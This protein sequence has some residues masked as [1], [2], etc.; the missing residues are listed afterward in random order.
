MRFAML[1][2]FALLSLCLVGPVAART[3]DTAGLRVMTFNVRYPNPDDGANVWANRRALFV[4]TIA[5]AAPDIIGTQELF[6]TQGADIVRALPRYAWFGRDRRGGHADEHMGIFYRRDRLRLIRHGDYWLSNTPSVVGSMAWSVTL[7]RMVNWG[8]FETRGRIR[9]RFVLFDT[10]F[11]H[12]DEDDGAR[13]RSAALLLDR[14]A[15]IAGNLPIVLTGDMN[16]TPDSPAYSKLAARLI[17]A[18]AAA[19]VRKGPERTFHDFTGLP[20]RRIDYIFLRGFTAQ[21]AEVRTDHAGKIFPSDHFPV[22]AQ[23]RFGM[24]ATSDQPA[25]RPRRHP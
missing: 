19:P 14:L 11:A 18:W 20:D 9:H 1:R 16:A 12:R 8:V 4:R 10:H 24:T 5:A 3:P 22:V 17:D 6:A 25:S 13:E 2:F 21:R 23:L 7:P 15:P